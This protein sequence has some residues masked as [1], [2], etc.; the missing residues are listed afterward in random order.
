MTSSARIT[1]GIVTMT[2][3]LAREAIHLARMHAREPIL[4]YVY[5]N[6]CDCSEVDADVVIPSPTNTGVVPGMQALM[7]AC[8]T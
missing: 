5:A 1:V 6:A 2:P 3:A 8:E 4:V 7:D